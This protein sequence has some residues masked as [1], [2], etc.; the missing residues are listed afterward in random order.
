MG[1]TLELRAEVASIRDSIELQTWVREKL[2]LKVPANGI[3]PG[4]V[5]PLEYLASAF[6][7][8]A[9]DLIV[10]GPRGGGKT[11]L[12]AVATL[13]DLLHK[14]QCQIKILGGSLEQ[15][16][17]MWDHLVPDIET[18]FGEDARLRSH[19]VTLLGEHGGAASVLAQSQ[20]SIR[21]VRIQKLRCDEVE[22]FH[23][24][25]WE[26]AQLVTRSLPG[27]RGSIEALSTFHRPGGMMQRLIDN[28]T[29]GNSRARVLKWCILDILE[30]CPDERDCE[31]CPLEE[32]C[33]GQ[34]KQPHVDGF[35]SIDDAIAM[36]QRVSK[37]TWESEMLCLR[38]SVRDCVFP[39]F[40]A[41]AHVSE[42][43]DA[44]ARLGEI[45]LAIDFGFASPFVCLWIAAGPDGMTRVL[46]EYIQDRLQL[47]K[48]MDHVESRPWPHAR[49]I[50]CDPAGNARNDQT[51]QSNIDLLRKRGYL[52][53]SRRSLIVDGLELIRTALSPASGPIGL[54][55][56]PRCQ[57][58]ITALGA[59]RYAP[60]HG[61]EPFKDGVHDH[62]VDA[63]RYYFI[64][65]ARHGARSRLT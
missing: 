33:H 16:L 48:H 40:S 58:L 47:D 34:A 5:G 61:E 13:L 49:K 63:L 11:R 6:F 30:H 24:D 51:A 41:A 25:I 45:W 52:V 9:Q 31:T 53:H 29:A 38:P 20:R 1:K 46:D 43:V 60:G 22:L 4:H 50:A 27:I 39:E 59:Y 35:F 64:N 56:H 18:F 3:C 28:A 17:R 19:K 14:P 21:G 2:R 55:I 10:W 42:G 8:P 32:D 36:K 23:P 44:Y 7:E 54:A 62:P 12:A 37:Q 57:G 26:A 65:H 15:S